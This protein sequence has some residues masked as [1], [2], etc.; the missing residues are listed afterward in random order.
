MSKSS[1]EFSTK[2]SANLSND[3][4]IKFLDSEF[5][6][7]IKLS[8]EAGDILF[9]KEEIKEFKIE[10]PEVN[11]SYRGQKNLHQRGKHAHRIDILFKSFIR[12]TRRYL[13]ELFEKEYDISL[14]VAQKTLTTLQRECDTILL[15]RF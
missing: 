10:D 5:K 2:F 4:F 6:A 3:E 11:L 13:W 15:K 1:N 14:L 12:W 9:T 8:D 7:E